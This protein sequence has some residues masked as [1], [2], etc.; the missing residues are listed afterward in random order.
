MS[1]NK[2][3]YQVS[4]KYLIMIS[5]SLDCDSV[6][7]AV[8]SI[9]QNDLKGQSTRYHRQTFPAV[10]YKKNQLKRAIN[11]ISQALDDIH[12]NMALETVFLLLKF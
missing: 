12:S 3:A 6:T 7:P 10:F 9:K 5:I 4:V 2:I 8:C 1:V 11:K